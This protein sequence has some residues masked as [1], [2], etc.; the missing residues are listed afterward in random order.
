MNFKGEFKFDTSRADGQF[1]KTASNEKLKKYLPLFKF[2]SF[3]QAM[4]ES[5]EWFLQNFETCRK[6]H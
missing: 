6:G 4:K 5:V 2:T 1:K 3:D